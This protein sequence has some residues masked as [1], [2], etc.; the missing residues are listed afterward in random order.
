MAAD[1]VS[2]SSEL[3]IELL[4]ND[5]DTRTI[6]L[7]NPKTTIASSEITALETL[8]LNSGDSLLISD[9]TGAQLNRIQT[10]TRIDTETTILGIDVIE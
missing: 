8:M 5:T 10:V 1:T 9:K 4:F 2:T 3:K 7:K 6:T